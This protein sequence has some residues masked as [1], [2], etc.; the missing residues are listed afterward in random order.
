MS[1]LDIKLKSGNNIELTDFKEFA[2]NSKD[3]Q[4]Y[5]DL[6]Q[7]N[8]SS[9]FVYTFFGSSSVTVRSED[10]LYLKLHSRD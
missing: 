1:R 8:L 6:K 4:T 5:T 2:T 3:C 10:I 7:I 9:G